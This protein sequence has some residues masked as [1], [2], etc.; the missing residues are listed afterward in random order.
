MRYDYFPKDQRVQS[1]R[2]RLIGVTTGATRPCQLEGCKGVRVTV[3]WPDGKHT[4][5][6]SEGLI[7]GRRQWR[8]A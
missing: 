8:I 7:A 6:C 2:G 1:R 4:H 5:P 3:K